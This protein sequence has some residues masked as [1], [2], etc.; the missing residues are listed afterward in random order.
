MSKNT[1]N[2]ILFVIL[3]MLVYFLFL[4]NDKKTI[5]EDLSKYYNQ[6][7]IN[8]TGSLPSNSKT[9][10]NVLQPNEPV[11]FRSQDPVNP[12]GEIKV[13]PPSQGKSQPILVQ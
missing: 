9:P 11:D 10:S 13:A 3:I 8:S 4:R 2:F 1:I 6:A 7:P 5:K 12:T